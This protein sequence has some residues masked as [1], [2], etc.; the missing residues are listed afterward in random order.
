MRIR[1][2]IMSGR[3]NLQGRTV[4]VIGAGQMI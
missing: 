3:G 1:K 2:E 4:I